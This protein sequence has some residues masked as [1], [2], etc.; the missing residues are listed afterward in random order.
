MYTLTISL[1]Q[2][3]QDGKIWGKGES[4]GVHR[5]ACDRMSCPEHRVVS[6]SVICAIF[7]KPQN[8]DMVEDTQGGR[9]SE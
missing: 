8:T 4:G 5:K 6:V 3:L 7:R 9:R 1:V 2:M